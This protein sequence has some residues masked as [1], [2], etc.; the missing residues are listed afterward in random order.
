MLHLY[1]KPP[2]CLTKAKSLVG[3]RSQDKKRVRRQSSGL[4]FP[5]LPSHLRTFEIIF[6]LVKDSLTGLPALLTRM[7]SVLG[8]PSPDLIT[9]LFF[10]IR[11]EFDVE[12]EERFKTWSACGVQI[13]KMLKYNF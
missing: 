9:Q 5:P 12:E 7:R 13:L 4:P 3:A 1:V 8:L 6:S 2:P 10:T 11:G